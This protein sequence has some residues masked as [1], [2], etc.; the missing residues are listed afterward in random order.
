MPPDLRSVIEAADRNFMDLFSRGDAAGMAELYTPDGQLLPPNS[1][2]VSGHDGIRRFWQG[3][4]DMGV[5][6][7]RLQPDEV[8]G[9]G[10]TV[11][12]IG[13]YTLGDGEGNE[14]DRGKYLVIWKKQDGS[15]K[16]HR[17]IWNTSLSA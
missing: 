14:L 13:R 4:M 9:P 8:E 7:A 2:V 11:V 6:T 12:E 1:E 16:L 15:W 5:K 3:V 10:D 17:D